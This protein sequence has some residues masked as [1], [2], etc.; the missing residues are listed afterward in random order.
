[1]ARNLSVAT[2]KLPSTG[3]GG[4]PSKLSPA[5]IEQFRT[6]VLEH[7]TASIDDLCVL[8]NQQLGVQLCQLSMYRYLK[9]VGIQRR[10]TI[11]DG[12]SGI[13][14]QDR[15]VPTE[16]PKRLQETPQTRYGY[17]ES[18][19]DDGDVKRYPGALTD[20]E[21]E[22][23]ADLFEHEGPGKP[24]KYPR[25]QLLD[26]CCYAVRTGCSWRMLPKD[27]PPWQDVYAHFR[28]WTA[29]NLFE[30]MHDRLRGMW[31]RR[32]G[33]DVAP[34]AAVI[35]SQSVKTSAQGGPKGFDAGKRV[36][37][38]KRHLVVDVL[39]LLLAVLVHPANIQER[40]G[41]A[42]LVAQA[43]EKFPSL[44]KL[45]VDGG[46]TGMCAH[47]L[48]TQYK[49]DVEVVRRPSA[50][51]TWSDSQLPLFA[52]EARPFPILP[53]RWVVERTHSWVERP[54]RLSKDYDRLLDVSAAWIWL[55]ET[56]IL[57]RRLST[58]ERV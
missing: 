50:A 32:E 2:K 4:R 3:A 25:R 57:L 56:R 26:A 44:R 24:P 21:W 20:A 7:P 46:Y 45:Y 23:I 28:R 19:R 55:A 52:T 35:D 58:A 29:K 13:P 30:T 49:L 48:R 40:D 18:H 16:T 9:R 54:R 47:S 36:K 38:R 17:T 14:K 41:A 6:L 31:R 1:M 8:V 34:T 39:G 27:L 53:R 15:V 22:L 12:R 42:P 10:K 37:G 51:G 33:R 11:V 5:A 43:V